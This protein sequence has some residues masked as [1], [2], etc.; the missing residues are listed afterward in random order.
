VRILVRIL[1]YLHPYW[2]RTL[3]AYL[4]LLLGI[5]MQL[6]IPRLVEYVIDG[7]IVGN[8]LSIITIGAIGIVAVGLLQGVFT[9]LRS[10]FF[11]LLAERVSF[12]VRNELYRHMQRLSFSFFDRAH[13]GQLMSRATEDVHS[14][15]R[16]L[17]FSLR[18]LV[19]AAVMLV[20]I[21][22]I[23]IVTDWRLA[24]LSLSVM[25]PLA[26]AAIH[27]GRTIR[28][29]FLDVQQQFGVMTSALQENLSGA[30]VVRAF[31]REQ[32]EAARFDRELEALYDRN[33]ATVAKSSFYF[34]L[35]M[36]LS[37]LGIA[38]ILWYGGRQ[39][40]AGQLTLG[41]LTAFYF[42]LALLAQTIRMLGWV[43]S[44]LARALASGQRVF[45][46]LDETPAIED[47]AGALTLDRVAGRVEFRDV[48]F[49]YP[50]T[51]EN[52]LSNISFRAEPG[53]TIALLGGPGS[54]KSTI[55]ALISRFYDV[56]AGAV[57]IDGVDVR[58]I[59][60]ASLRRHIGTVPQ[61]T[62]LFSVSIRENIVY[63]R[64]DATDEQIVAAAVAA[65]AHDFITAL[66]EGYDT[67]VGER[68][69]SLSGG[70]KQRVAIARALLMDPEILILDDATSNVDTNTEF[71]IQQA[72]SELME[73]RTTFVIAQRLL[74]LKRADEILVL[75]RGRIIERGSHQELM[76]LG[77]R[78]RRIY[79]LQLKP[80]EEFIAARIELNNVAL[81]RRC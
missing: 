61:D 42:Y 26:W 27:F 46:V 59:S 63:G 6:T 5:A 53:R 28:P 24:L 2:R 21:S 57:L 23:L 25:P 79:D 11:Q 47:A 18:F 58:D 45:Q 38:F 41:Q 73:G 49:R 40:V 65:R 29:L 33:M 31:A 54:G 68:G 56:S 36:L 77:G 19:Q 7:G 39:V 64:P 80:Q 43:V 52:A 69:I 12:D 74:S 20:A 13:T 44:S 60:L 14:I 55:T 8:D 72:L 75:D 66:S 10:Y 67:V 51:T 3:L 48:S 32:D 34:P 35:M 15:R 81:S 76:A 4:V 70:Q 78:Y 30:R 37:S 9:Y 17:M 50:G 16:F 71:E 22:V 62:F 1:S